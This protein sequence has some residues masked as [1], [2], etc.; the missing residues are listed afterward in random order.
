ML[1][2]ESVDKTVF[3]LISALLGKDYLKDFILVGGTGL[4]LI[5]G[6]RK[7]VVIDL[8]TSQDFVA[9]QVLEKLESDFAFQMDYIGGNTIKGSSAGIKVDLLAHK[10]P[11]IGDTIEIDADV[12][13]GDVAIWYQDN[14]TIRGVGGGRAHL[15]AN[16]NNAEGKGI[17]VIKGNNTVVENIEFSEST[18]PDENG[19]GIRQEG[20][21]LTVRNCSFHDNENGILVPIKNPIKLAEAIQYLL[22]NEEV[23][24]TLGI[25]GRKFIIKNF[26]LE[27]TMNKLYK[28]YKE[29]TSR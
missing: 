9:E 2:K 22:N 28:I 16:G 13:E 7:S 3:E 8:F 18:V 5:I 10:Y 12:Y 6:H 29:I 4:A 24:T 20:A 23:R 14:L 17:W 11:T 15:K 21:G 19:A 27:A 25:K 1:Q 26:S